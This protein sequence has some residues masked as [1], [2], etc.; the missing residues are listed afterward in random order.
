MTSD[1]FWRKVMGLTDYA[2][3]P[4]MC[5]GW[6]GGKEELR[7][8]LIVAGADRDDEGAF[9]LSGNITSFMG[10][11]DEFVVGADAVYFVG[12]EA[13]SLVE[14]LGQTGGGLKVKVI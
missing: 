9:I 2:K 7:A 3:E 1:A 10:A 14:A 11:G 13:K 6:V 8:A 4:K 12:G 5:T